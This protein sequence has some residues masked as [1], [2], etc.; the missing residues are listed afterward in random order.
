MA[1]RS[2]QCA[3]VLPLHTALLAESLSH[4]SSADVSRPCGGI[5]W[6][7]C[8]IMGMAKH[9]LPAFTMWSWWLQGQQSQACLLIDKQQA[10]TAIAAAQ[11]IIAAG[12]LGGQVI[13]WAAV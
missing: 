1:A 12:L 11:N 8:L 2:Q 7:S 5:I 3:D 4:A 9:Q 13:I 6:T 10:V